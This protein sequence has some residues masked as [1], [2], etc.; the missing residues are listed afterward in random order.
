[1]ILMCSVSHTFYAFL[2]NA[3]H[4]SFHLLGSNLVDHPLHVC[5]WNRL[6]GEA[7]CAEMCI[8][9]NLSTC[10]SYPVYK[11]DIWPIWSPRPPNVK[12]SFNGPIFVCVCV[13]VW[14]CVYVRFCFNLLLSFGFW[15]VSI[16]MLYHS[17]ESYIFHI[18]LYIYIFVLKT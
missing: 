14:V 13:S 4:L 11:S 10:W 18:I 7:I 5:W 8:Y 12:Q 3:V 17:Y 6:V 2:F 1:M 9:I 15:E 16:S